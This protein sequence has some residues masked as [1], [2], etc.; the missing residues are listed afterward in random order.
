ML[1]QSM[2]IQ[3]SEFNEKLSYITPTTRNE[4]EEEKRQRKRKIILR[5]QQM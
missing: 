3:A 2:K 4:D 1:L 5:I